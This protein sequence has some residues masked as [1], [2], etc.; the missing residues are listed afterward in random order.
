MATSIS[1]SDTGSFFAPLRGEGPFRIACITTGRGTCT[2]AAL[3]KDVNTG[4]GRFFFV[5]FGGSNRESPRAHHW[6]WHS[7][8]SRRLH[9]PSKRPVARDS[10]RRLVRLDGQ[11]V[12]GR[13]NVNSRSAVASICAQTAPSPMAR[14]TPKRLASLLAARG[15]G[16]EAFPTARAMEIGARAAGRR[17]GRERWHGSSRSRLSSIERTRCAR[18]GNEAG[19]RP[20]RHARARHWYLHVALGSAQLLVRLVWRRARGGGNVNSRRPRSPAFSAQN[21]LSSIARAASKRL[22]SLLAAR[23][24]GPEA[25][26]TARAMEIGGRAAGRRA[27]RERWHGSS[28]SRLSSIERTR[29]ASSST[30]GAIRPHRHARARHWYL[31]VALGSA[32]LLVRL[33]RPRTRGGGNVNSRRGVAPKWPNSCRCAAVP[34]LVLLFVPF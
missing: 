30:M 13:R 1:Q 34:P 23:G 18:S 33:V 21:V 4:A 26:P 5:R 14:A 6:R 25:L 9:S 24:G 31:H 3:W 11:R 16:A 15:G 32:R 29:C 19:I 8:A 7:A 28:R 17:A 27:G 2:G 22:A 10:A 20:H 12:N